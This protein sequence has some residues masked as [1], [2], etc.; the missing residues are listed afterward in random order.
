M[1]LEPTPFH[2][3]AVEPLQFTESKLAIARQDLGSTF[4]AVHNA[5]GFCSTE[6]TPPYPSPDKTVLFVGA[7]ISVWKPEIDAIHEG[8]MP[9]LITSQDCLR[10][11]NIGSFYDESGGPFCSYFRTH[12]VIAPAS[13]FTDMVKTAHQYLLALGIAP[14]DILIKTDTELAAAIDTPVG[15]LLDSESDKYYRWGYG[16]PD[17]SGHGITLAVRNKER[18]QLHDI[19]NVITIYKNGEPWVC[20][21]GFGEE[22]LLASVHGANHAILFSDLPIQLRDQLHDR[23]A[24]KYVDAI[25]ASS[26]IAKLGVQPGDRGAAGALNEYLSGIAYL[27][28]KQQKTI[29]NMESDLDSMASH[30]GLA[31]IP[32][33]ML[34]DRL[35]YYSGRIQYVLAICNNLTPEPTI[36]ITDQRFLSIL[37]ISP[38]LARALLTTQEGDQA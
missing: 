37:K 36:S 19:G 28:T 4:H 21:W 23:T 30:I 15:L 5:A 11:Q 34:K 27:G 6:E 13:Q 24:Y 14:D 25:L 29:F 33:E 2:M 18:Q 31:S 32:A 26:H 8:T 35:R 38:D 16:E 12:G 22:T 20:E 7:Q 17:L 10:L 3:T 9:P 1:K